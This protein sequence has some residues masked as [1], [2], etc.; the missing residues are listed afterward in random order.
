[1]PPA[2]RLAVCQLA[3]ALVQKG[4]IAVYHRLKDQ[5]MLCIAVNFQ[6]GDAR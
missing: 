3:K 5:I 6:R 4:G 1:M 2:V